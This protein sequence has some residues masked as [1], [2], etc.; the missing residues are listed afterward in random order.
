MRYIA[1]T[2]GIALGTLPLFMLLKPVNA[3]TLDLLP[4]MQNITVGD[5]VIIDVQI[6]ELGNGTSPSVGGF[7][8]E[9]NYDPAVLTFNNL[10]FSE[11]LNIFDTGIQSIDSSTSGTLI[12]GNVSL[13]SAEE[14]NAAQP[15]SFSLANIEFI[16]SGVSTNSPLSLSIIELVDENFAEFDPVTQNDTIVTVSSAITKVPESSLGLTGWGVLLGLYWMI[17]QKKAIHLN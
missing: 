6:S 10:T 13:D 4:E 14:L 2:C 15:N 16:G 12:F 9:L 1:V 11:L 3:V 7:N 5:S 17:T 8:L